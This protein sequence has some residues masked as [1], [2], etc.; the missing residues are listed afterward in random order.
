MHKTC[1]G[2]LSFQVPLCTKEVKVD[3]MFHVPSCTKHVIVDANFR[4]PSC[5]THVKV[6][7]HFHVALCTTQS[8]RGRW[9]F[10]CTIRLKTCI[11]KRGQEWYICFAQIYFCFPKKVAKF[12]YMMQTVKNGRVLTKQIRS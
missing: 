6:D 12:I 5:R 9:K 3:G 1:K 11:S 10:P 7:G 2:R 8:V 4:V